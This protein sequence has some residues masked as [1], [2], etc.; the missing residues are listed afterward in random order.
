ML[1][2][3]HFTEHYKSDFTKQSLEYYMSWVVLQLR[4]W[5]FVIKNVFLYKKYS[6]NILNLFLHILFFGFF[7]RVFYLL[8]LKYTCKNSKTTKKDFQQIKIIFEQELK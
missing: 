5:Y 3:P 6:P 8:F 4:L 2:K 7:F 1:Q